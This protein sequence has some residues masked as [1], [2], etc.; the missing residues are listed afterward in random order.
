MV[1]SISIQHEYLRLIICLD[2][3]EWFRVVLSNINYSVQYSSFICLPWSG[4]NYYYL[5]LIILLN[6]TPLLAHNE[7]VPN[8]AIYH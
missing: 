5:T 8:I 1:S 7:S 6:L 3:V 2:R 4:Y